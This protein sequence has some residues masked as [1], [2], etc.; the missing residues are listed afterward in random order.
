MES[1]V[2]LTIALGK[3]TDF[4]PIYT[5]VETETLRAYVTTQIIHRARG[6]A[7]LNP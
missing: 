6:R 4:T 7:G 1:L 3:G 5:I 2:F